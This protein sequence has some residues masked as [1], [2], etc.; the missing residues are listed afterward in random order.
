MCHNYVGTTSENN[1][2]EFL[3]SIVSTRRVYNELS[4]IKQS[5]SSHANN[6]DGQQICYCISPFEFSW[7]CEAVV[8][9]AYLVCVGVSNGRAATN[10]ACSPS[11]QSLRAQM[12]ESR[13]PERQVKSG[14]QQQQRKQ[15][16]RLKRTSAS[17][18][19]PEM[20]SRPRRHSPSVL[21]I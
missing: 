19:P 20:P 9:A 18:L 2:S 11:L 12:A 16:V 14:R 4:F 3:V 8:C 7:W 10:P 6:I 13:T 15:C 21:S 17:I 5:N 1:V